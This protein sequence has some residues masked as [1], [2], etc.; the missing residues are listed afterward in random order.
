MI[1]IL[2]KIGECSDIYTL[3]YKKY[4]LYVLEELHKT[5]PL[6][7]DYYI[8]CF[9]C[10]FTDQKYIQRYVKTEYGY[11]YSNSYEF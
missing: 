5:V 3:I 7:N 8:D 11:I 2:K 1:D 6:N 10:T 4:Y 9:F